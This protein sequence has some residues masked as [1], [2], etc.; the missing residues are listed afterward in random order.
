MQRTYLVLLVFLM[1]IQLA[2]QTHRAAGFEGRN[3]LCANLLGP[4]KIDG[5]MVYP[6][7]NGVSAPALVKGTKPIVP[8]DKASLKGTAIVCG[9]VARDGR[10]HNAG[11]DRSLG[12]GLDQIALD[13]VKQWEFRPAMRDGE[14]VAAPITLQ[15]K[16][17]N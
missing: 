16:F 4:K 8:S 13:T 15:I 11:I 12:N 9:I 14:P 2:A 10:I 6:V 1:V 17:G 5:E 3:P 7:G